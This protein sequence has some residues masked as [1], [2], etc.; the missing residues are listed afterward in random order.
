MCLFVLRV[1][2][3]GCMILEINNNMFYIIGSIL[4]SCR[5][6]SAKNVY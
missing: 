1:K 3:I 6:H 2:E 4:L 5:L